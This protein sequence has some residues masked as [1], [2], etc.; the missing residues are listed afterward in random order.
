MAISV[1]WDDETQKIIRFDFEGKW[2]LVA[3]DS[4]VDY[5]AELIYAQHNPVD[6]ILNNPGR[7]LPPNIFEAFKRMIM[8]MP[9]DSLTVI[10]DNNA[11]INTLVRTFQRLY[12]ELGDYIRRLPVIDFEP[13]RMAAPFLPELAL[14]EISQTVKP[15]PDGSPV[16]HRV[17]QIRRKRTAVGNHVLSFVYGPLDGAARRGH[18]GGR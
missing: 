15:A 12:G 4:A 5:A 6:V 14:P 13:P 17:N 3:F 11:S 16:L 10:V 1:R 18:A 9:E 7:N 8:A 2:S